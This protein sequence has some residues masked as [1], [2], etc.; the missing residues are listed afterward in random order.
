MALGMGVSIKP[1][2]RH[3]V[4]GYGARPLFALLPSDSSD[5]KGYADR[6]VGPRGAGKR[7]RLCCTRHLA[8]KK[9]TGAFGVNRILLTRL[10]VIP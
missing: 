1:R 9:T 7:P 5:A 3:V 10:H 4:S 6:Q 8:G 2:S